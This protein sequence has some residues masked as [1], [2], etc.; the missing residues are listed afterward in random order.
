MKIG[1]LALQ[2]DF[3]LHGKALDRVGVESA[4]VRTPEELDAVDGLIVPGGESTTLLKLMD[5]GRFVPA[6]EKFH[7]DGRPIFGTCAG[8]IVLAREVLNPKQFSLGLIDV[9][10]ERNAYGRQKESFEAE[11]E[12]TLE[13]QP[14]SLSMVFIR[15]PRIRRLGPRVVS[16]AS[17][18][19]DC[20]MAREGTVLV[21][22]FHPELTDD[23]TIHRY[24]TEMVRHAAQ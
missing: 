11:G 9:T 10:V 23:P 7:A 3:A 18:R 5:A 17:H 14:R 16:L 13:G 6:L 12:T 20:V 21:A 8:L 4:E 15:A 1:V 22:T 24:F 2:G 19:G